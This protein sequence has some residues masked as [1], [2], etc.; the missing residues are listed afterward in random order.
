MNRNLLFFT[1]V[2]LY[3][4][5]FQSFAEELVNTTTADDEAELSILIRDEDEY[6][7]PSELEN[8]DIKNR[9]TFNFSQGL[10]IITDIDAV[11]VYITDA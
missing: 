2:F 7:R 6:D 1:P 10:E 4:I 9:Q 5:L 11:K 3:F 8:E